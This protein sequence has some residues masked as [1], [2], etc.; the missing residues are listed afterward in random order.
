MK[1]V[2]GSNFLS[3]LASNAF[4]HHIN[5]CCVGDIDGLLIDWAPTESLDIASQTH[6]RL[7]VTCVLDGNQSAISVLDREVGAV[8]RVRIERVFAG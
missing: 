4:G 3:L 6:A 8:S 1:D 5:R 7:E 2:Y